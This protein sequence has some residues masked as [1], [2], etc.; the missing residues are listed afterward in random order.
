MSSNG[1][2]LASSRLAR[3]CLIGIGAIAI[4][5]L[6]VY[7]LLRI[8]DDSIINPLNEA[9]KGRTTTAVVKAKEYVRFDEKNHWYVNNSGEI[10]EATPGTEQWRI[11]YQID[12]FDQVPEPKRSQL[13]QSEQTRIE[14]FGFRFHPLSTP[15]KSFYEKTQIGDR[16]EIL[17]RYMSDEKEIIHVQNLTH[18]DS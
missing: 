9:K 1:K 8:V 14:K 6:S 11:Y 7:L 3:W 12:N 5:G 4:I 18:P 2:S 10:V 13:W 16:L 17:Y 15:E